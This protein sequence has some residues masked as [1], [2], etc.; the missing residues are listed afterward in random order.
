MN[1]FA[2]QAQGITKF[3]KLGLDKWLSV[4]QIEVKDYG[5]ID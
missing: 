1:V 5:E 4:G 2:T 3:E